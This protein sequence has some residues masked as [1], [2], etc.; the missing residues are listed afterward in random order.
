MYDSRSLC[1]FRGG[2][3]QRWQVTTGDSFHLYVL[4]ENKWALSHV[5]KTYG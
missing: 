3:I 4:E 1:A 2:F 5:Q